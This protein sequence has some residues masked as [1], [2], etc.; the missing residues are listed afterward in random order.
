MKS[1]LLSSLKKPSDLN[2]ISLGAKNETSKD[3]LPHSKTVMNLTYEV[4]N[5][6][7]CRE[8]PEVLSHE[9]RCWDSVY[10]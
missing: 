7:Q 4:L 6:V 5:L 10:E 9:S 8:N 2:D 1:Q 3:T